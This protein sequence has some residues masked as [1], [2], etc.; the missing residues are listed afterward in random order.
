MPGKRK[1]WLKTTED[2]LAQLYVENKYGREK[3][4]ESKYLKKGTQ[5]EEDS[6]TLYSRYLNKIFVKN[7]KWYQNKFIT[8]TPDIVHKGIV[9]DI[10]TSWD[11][12]TFFANTDSEVKDDYYWQ[13]QGYM[14]LTGAEKAKLAY[15]LVNTPFGLIEQE[16]RSL[17]Y[18]TGLNEDDPIHREACKEIEKLCVYDDIPLEERVII[19]D[20][21]RNEE[22][23]AK[24][25]ERVEQ[26]RAWM[27]EKFG[28]VI[29]A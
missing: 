2:Y 1:R 26:C 9:H 19:Q 23:I 17:M 10:K 22:D 24:I 25:Y 13:L 5:A 4:I 16:K 18:K 21:E 6:L 11:L 8:G 20:V 27:K 3:E 14:A 12:F 29:A 15:C 7:E 28:E